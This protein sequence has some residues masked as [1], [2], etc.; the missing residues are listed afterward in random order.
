MSMPP[1]R[2]QRAAH[3]GAA[4]AQVR[5][6]LLAAIVEHHPDA[7]GCLPLPAF[8]LPDPAGYAIACTAVYSS[9]FT[10][11]GHRAEVWTAARASCP[12]GEEA[13]LT[14]YE[15]AYIWYQWLAAAKYYVQ[16]GCRERLDLLRPLL[17]AGIARAGR[18][19]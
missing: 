19:C 6:R 4:L 11:A 7:A 9:L 5:V 10:P 8:E 17:S 15:L 18:A 13:V 12:H 14:V 2:E 16:D 3:A 1:T